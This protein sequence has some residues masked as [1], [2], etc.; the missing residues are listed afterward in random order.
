M[1]KRISARNVFLLLCVICV[2]H[3]A[4]YYPRLP[5]RVA[6]HFG[7]TGLADAWGPKSR[8]LLIYLVTLAILAVSFSVPSLFLPRIRNSLISLP[9]KDEWLAPE[10]RQQT[11][12]TILSQLFCFGS[13]TLILL[14]DIFHQSIQVNL[15]K[16]TRLE[17]VWITLGMYLILTTAWCIAFFRRF[18]KKR[19]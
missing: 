6:L 13:I 3:A 8:F 11:I 2:A 18:R 9:N 15:G 7:A 17:H 1:N 4:W 5:G 10:R 12:D 19:T 16:A 14:L